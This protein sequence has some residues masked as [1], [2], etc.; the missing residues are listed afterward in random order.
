MQIKIIKNIN[1]LGLDFINCYHFINEKEGKFN[2]TDKIKLVK[3]FTKK[4]VSK[5]KV[6]DINKVFEE[7]VNTLAQYKPKEIPLS[8]EM[9]GVTY[10]L[11]TDY[12][13][14]PASWFIDS[15]GADFE[16]IPELLPAFAYLE[17]G[18]SYAETDEHENIKNPLKNR[19]EA[20][21]KYMTLPQYLDLIGFFLLKQKQFKVIYPLIQLKKQ[22]ERKKRSLLLSNGRELSTQWLRNFGRIGKKL[23]S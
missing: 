23:L 11:I 2:I 9:D 10:E 6:S 3:L 14:L 13:K 16:N 18:M 8:V 15:E 5:V 17:K 12:F 21:K 20:F 19:A 22:K 4:D 1:K 7:I